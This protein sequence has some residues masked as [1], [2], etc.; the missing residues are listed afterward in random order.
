MYF[1]VN[2]QAESNLMTDIPSVMKKTITNFK[3]P[4]KCEARQFI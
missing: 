4:F 1:K 2:I 3:K